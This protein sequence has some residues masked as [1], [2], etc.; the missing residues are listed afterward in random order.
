MLVQKLGT[1]TAL[2]LATFSFNINNLNE[3][4]PGFLF[5]SARPAS[6]QR[7]WARLNKTG[8][9]FAKSI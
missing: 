9:C 8:R 7:G 3:N 6:P 2:F 4:N 5:W 1:D